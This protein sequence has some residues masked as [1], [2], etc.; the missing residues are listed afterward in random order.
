MSGRVQH[1]FFEWRII[2][3]FHASEG[4]NKDMARGELHEADREM[5]NFRFWISREYEPMP[6]SS[7]AG[8]KPSG[9]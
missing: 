2:K 1:L 3:R 6:F 5:E 4:T 7:R 9:I 8:S